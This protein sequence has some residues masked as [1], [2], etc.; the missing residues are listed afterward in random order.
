VRN[1]NVAAVAFHTVI[2]FVELSA[3]LTAGVV[4]LAALTAVVAGTEPPCSRPW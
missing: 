4:E 2:D 3:A 1:A